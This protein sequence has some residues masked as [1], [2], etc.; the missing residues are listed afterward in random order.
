M[1]RILRGEAGSQVCQP[2]GSY[3]TELRMGSEQVEVQGSL[4][5]DSDMMEAHQPGWV[6]ARYSVPTPLA[7]CF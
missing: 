5:V 2:G 6:R 1:A 4:S 7:G 3:N